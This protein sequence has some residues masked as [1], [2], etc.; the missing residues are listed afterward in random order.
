MT[1]GDLLSIVTWVVTGAI[2]G[3]V[4][5]VL[6]RAERNGCLVNMVLGIAG[7]FVGGFVM[8]AILLPQGLTGVGFIDAIV[9]AIVGAVIIL[10][11]IELVIPGRQLGVRKRETGKKRSFNPLDWLE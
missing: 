5:S 3:Y 6:L 9:N 4:A 11:V 1:L 10:I 7:A 2:A 8:N